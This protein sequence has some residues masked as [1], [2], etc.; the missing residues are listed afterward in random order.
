MQGMQGESDAVSLASMGPRSSDRGNGHDV[1]RD[2]V[3][4][5]LLQWGRDHLIAEIGATSARFRAGDRASMG[6]R[7]SDRG[8]SRSL[9]HRATPLPASM[10]PRSSDRGN[11]APDWQIIHGKRASMGPRSSDRGNP[12]PF[13]PAHHTCPSFNGAAII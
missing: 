10:G 3:H 13:G 4:Q 6:P 11:D 7:S 9:R 12:Y 1:E 8:N 5:E 2:G